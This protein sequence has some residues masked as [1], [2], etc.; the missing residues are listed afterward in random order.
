MK[1]FVNL[2]LFVLLIVTIIFAAAI[3]QRNQSLQDSNALFGGELEDGYPAAG[4]LIITTKTGGTKLCGYAVLNNKVAVTAGHCIDDSASVEMG[5][6]KFSPNISDHLK[7][8]KAIQKENWAREKTRSDDFAIMQFTDNKNFFKTFAEVTTPVEGCRYRVVAYGRTEDPAELANP[9]RKSARLCAYE[10]NAKTFR[11]KGDGTSG[12]CFGDSGSPIFYEGTNNLVGNIV[13]I[14]NEDPNKKDPCGLG[15]TAIVVRTDYNKRL[16]EENVQ[17]K[18]PYAEALDIIDGY[19]V[20]VS[21]ETFLDRV[22]LG[23]LQYLDEKSKNQLALFFIGG[24][25]VV[26]L[27]GLIVQLVRPNQTTY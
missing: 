5:V 3:V 9:P 25:I 23:Q 18:D 21:G 15:N 27:I 14:I 22:G 26:T 7:V 13:S 12:I 1:K 2:V 10:I 20:S 19:S 17:E 8:E 24:L 4:Y 16:I 11:V 6:G